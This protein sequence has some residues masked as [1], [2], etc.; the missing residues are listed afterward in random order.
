MPK[1]FCFCAFTD[2]S[3]NTSKTFLPWKAVPTIAHSVVYLV[4]DEISKKK[5]NNIP[6]WGEIAGQLH[7]IFGERADIDIKRF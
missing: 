5:T 6:N 2:G 3:C 4:I 1:T 7:L